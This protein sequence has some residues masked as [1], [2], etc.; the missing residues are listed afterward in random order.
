MLGFWTLFTR[1]VNPECILKEHV[2]KMRCM[3]HGIDNTPFHFAI[4]NNNVFFHMI[5]SSNHNSLKIRFFGKVNYIWL[6]KDAMMWWLQSQ[7]WEKKY[8]PTNF[9]NLRP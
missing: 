4:R 3:S 5:K 1:L 7:K 6:Y 2:S 9:L 8:L